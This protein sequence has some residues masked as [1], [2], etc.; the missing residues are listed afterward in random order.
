MVSSPRILAVITARGGSKRVPGKNIRP[1]AGKPLLA[2][3]AESVLACKDLLHDVILSTDDE[4]IAAVGRTHG[5]SV[6]F[7]RPMSL[8]TDAS[9]SLVVMQH[10]TRFVEERD[11]TK[12]DWL[13]LLQ[14]TSP[15]RTAED[16]R[17]AIGLIATNNC[18]SI[19]AVSE[20]P[21]HPVYAKKIDNDGLLRPFLLD[22]PEGL[23]RQD[24]KPLAY[25]RNGALYMTRRDILMERNTLYGERI[26]PYIM[27]RERSIDIDTEIDFMLAELLLTTHKER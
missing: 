27:P 16:I 17:H 13:L 20:M 11:A 6:P 26:C 9:G 10:A 8:A 24:V 1:I 4:A 22:E 21:T 12:M 2:W 25:M 7:L 15:L 23:R 5:I 14:P 3:T 19:V 18:D